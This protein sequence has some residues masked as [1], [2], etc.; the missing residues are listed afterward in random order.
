MKE[1]RTMNDAEMLID[2]ILRHIPGTQKAKKVFKK[3]WKEIREAYNDEWQE[4]YN[5]CIKNG[6]DGGNID[7]E[8]LFDTY[9]KDELEQL[10][11]EH[12]NINIRPETSLC[13]DDAY[14]REY[15]AKL[16][17]VLNGT[18]EEIFHEAP[19]VNDFYEFTTED[20][21]T[22]KIKVTDDGEIADYISDITGWLVYYDIYRITLV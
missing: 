22:F 13:K 2:N 9:V 21:G 15:A 8:D 5:D 11:A 1:I 7:E 3:E 12:L 6:C 18:I 19:D 14:G 10:L 17:K 20:D 16:R 4:E